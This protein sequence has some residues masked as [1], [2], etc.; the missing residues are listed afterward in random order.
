MQITVHWL[1]MSLLLKLFTVCMKG[2]F[3]ERK[4][5][6]RFRKLKVLPFIRPCLQPEKKRKKRIGAQKRVKMR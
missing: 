6:I 4:E 1:S 2:G 5:Q 3:Q